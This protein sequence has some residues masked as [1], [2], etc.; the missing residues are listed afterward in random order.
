MS[1]SLKKYFIKVIRSVSDTPTQKISLSQTRALR[2]VLAPSASRP[3]CY[4]F[5]GVRR[6]INA[7]TSAASFRTF[8][9]ELCMSFPA[10]E[11]FAGAGFRGF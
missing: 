6:G 10:R 5:G 4:F 7:S 8:G 3:F 11:D 9:L 2:L 1:I